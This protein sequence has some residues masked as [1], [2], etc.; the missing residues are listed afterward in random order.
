[1]H[2]PYVIKFEISN[3]LKAMHNEHSFSSSIVY[4]L[5]PTEINYVK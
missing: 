5:V 4:C 1:M 2:S 3:Y